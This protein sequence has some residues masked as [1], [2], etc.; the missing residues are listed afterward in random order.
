ILSPAEYLAFERAAPSRHQYLDGILYAMAGESPEHGIISAN[1]GAAIHAQVKG[2]P[3]V[4]FFK[5]TKVRSGPIGPTSGIGRDLFSY[6]DVVVVCGEAEYYDEKK[7]VVLNPK[8][9]VEV[10]SPS[11]ESF[12]RGEKYL[13][14]QTWN[15]SLTDYVLVSQNEAAVERFF[16]REDGTW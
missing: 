15:P 2:T 8:V 6:P 7:D 4:A 3:C 12:D 16:K 1:V 9:I 5:E 13:R 11:T 14:Y 10:L